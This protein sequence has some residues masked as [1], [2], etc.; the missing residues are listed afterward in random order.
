MQPI[1]AA[2]LVFCALFVSKELSRRGP[3]NEGDRVISNRSGE[4]WGSSS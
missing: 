3:S 4:M 1:C 2:E